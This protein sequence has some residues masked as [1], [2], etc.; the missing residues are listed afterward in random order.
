MF[1][2]SKENPFTCLFYIINTSVQLQT[3]PYDTVLAITSM[4]NIYNRLHIYVDPDEHRS[5]YVFGVLLF[6][7]LQIYFGV[8]CILS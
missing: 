1:S 4:S 2:N 8:S 3:H 7:A 6:F 5:H